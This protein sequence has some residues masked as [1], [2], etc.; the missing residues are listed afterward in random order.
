M[1]EL[2]VIYQFD[3]EEEAL[4]AAD[5]YSEDGIQTEVKK[6]DDWRERRRQGRDEVF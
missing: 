2:H 3:T 1:F 6:A 4:F 5:M